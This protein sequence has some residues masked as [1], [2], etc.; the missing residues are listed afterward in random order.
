MAASPSRD[1]LLSKSRYHNWPTKTY[2]LS[3]KASFCNY[4]SFYHIFSFSLCQRKTKWLP[5]IYLT[6]SRTST[7]I[8]DQMLPDPRFQPSIRALSILES[9]GISRSEYSFR[10][11]S[12]CM[13]LLSFTWWRSFSFRLISIFK[14]VSLFFFL[15]DS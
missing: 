5:N 12:F 13:Q 2:K 3:R 15:D 6:F 4:S 10:T 7:H 14:V 9:L 1:S 8:P 11:R